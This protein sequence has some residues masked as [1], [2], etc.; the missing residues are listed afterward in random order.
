VGLVFGFIVF[1]FGLL[2]AGLF[3]IRTFVFNWQLFIIVRIALNYLSFHA[4]EFFTYLW[5]ST[6]FH[7]LHYWF[8]VLNKLKCFILKNV[9]VDNWTVLSDLCLMKPWPRQPLII[10]SNFPKYAEGSPRMRMILKVV[11][12]I[13]TFKNEHRLG[14]QGFF[15]V[16]IG[17]VWFLI[18]FWFGKLWWSWF[19]GS[20]L[21]HGLH[22]DFLFSF[23]VLAI[24]IIVDRLIGLPAFTL[25]FL[26]TF[27]I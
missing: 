12:E 8:F 19:F 25:S 15:V 7:L 11:G 22:A 23:L 13:I 1:L 17:V 3:W 21:I 24:L 5:K 4:Y 6:A 14:T 18:K 10:N 9:A 26:H 2:N 27:L 16:L 20:D